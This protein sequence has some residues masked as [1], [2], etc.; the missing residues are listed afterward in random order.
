LLLATC[1]GL[2]AGAP[3]VAQEHVIMPY[4]CS[5]RHGR[6]V[7]EPSAERSYAVLGRHEQQPFTGCSPTDEMRCRTWMLH[8]FDLDCGGT[9]VSWLSTVAAA[10]A[11]RSRRVWVEDGRLSL[12]FWAERV[13]A[14]G[15]PCF[16]RP[17]H[18]REAWPGQGPFLYNRACGPF[19]ARE[20]ATVVR[21]P[22][23]FAPV[24]GL[25]A[26]F[27]SGPPSLAAAADE[28]VRRSMPAAATGRT[29][30]E[31][32]IAP[33]TH[34]SVSAS[35][36]PAASTGERSP[37]PLPHRVEAHESLA[38]SAKSAVSDAERASWSATTHPARTVWLQNSAED[39]WNAFLRAMAEPGLPLTLGVIGAFGLSLAAVGWM[40]SRQGAQVADLAIAS[41]QHGRPFA[42]LDSPPPLSPTEEAAGEELM[43]TA[44][45]FFAHVAHIAQ[46]MRA[47]DAL[48]DVVSDELRGI[49][50]TLR[51]PELAR[52]YAAK[53]WSFVRA[54]AVQ[55]LT[56]LE[57][58]RRVAQSANEMAGV[59]TR[60]GLGTAAPADRDEAL[61]VLGVNADASEK[62][63]KKI[64]D[65]MRQTWHP[66]LA[67][68]DVDRR[69]REERIKQINNAW[70]LVRKRRQEA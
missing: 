19:R 9:R 12:R 17:W 56:D 36:K 7:L 32:G 66:D 37:T 10:A 38:A 11:G 58:V 23:G 14:S 28:P 69:A 60:G 42:A 51:S 3:A 2:G 1:L 39:V 52:A 16:V 15:N 68:D 5:V 70:D 44:E 31:T 8:R 57:R 27:A 24:M 34:V 33:R 45:S 63:I 22:H 49:E 20:A 48:R 25:G 18:A 59:G 6:V 54:R 21:M 43:R 35:A 30:S 26:R 50:D 13:D 64:V 4:A 47:R 53:D 40:R 55:I 65:A 46:R 67:R 62:V 61:A 29:P 41:Y